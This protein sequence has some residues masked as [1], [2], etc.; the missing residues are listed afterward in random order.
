[1]LDPLAASLTQARSVEG[2]MP[3]R[4]WRISPD[5]YATE[6]SSSSAFNARRHSASSRI[7]AERA[8]V[9]A[10]RREVSTTVAS[11]VIDSS[12]SGRTEVAPHSGSAARTSQPSYRKEKK[13]SAT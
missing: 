4:P 12:Y 7:L 10:T 8:E 11:R 5:R 6:I 1:M 13:P 9:V 2:P 3:M